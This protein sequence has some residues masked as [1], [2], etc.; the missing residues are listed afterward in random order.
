MRR[1]SSLFVSFANVSVPIVAALLCKGYGLGAMSMTVG[2]FLSPSYLASRPTGEIG[3]MGLEGAVT[4]GFKKELAAVEDEQERRELFDR[5]VAEKY[6]K[7]KASEAAVHLEI[8]AVIDPA[9]TRA[10]IRKAL[11]AASL[12]G[13][14]RGQRRNLVD[15]W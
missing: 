15:T 10:V 1:M 2:S 5:L 8:D 13:R 7:G 11:S 3:P 6:E 4:L 9:D 14:P 12:S